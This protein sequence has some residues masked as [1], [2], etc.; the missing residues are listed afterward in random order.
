[1]PANASARDERFDIGRV[2]LELLDVDDV[3]FDGLASVADEAH[4][5]L[6]HGQVW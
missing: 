4:R 6:D 3:G 2:G 1:L 5:P